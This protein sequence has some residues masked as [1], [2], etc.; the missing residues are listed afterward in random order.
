MN[1]AVGWVLYVGLVLW[2]GF[3]VVWSLDLDFGFSAAIA[4]V[5]GLVDF[6]GLVTGALVW[7]F[8]S[9]LLSCLFFGFLGPIF[10]CWFLFFCGCLC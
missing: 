4:L 7:R 10:G 3:T 5:L 1:F 8:Y 9:L 6:G 2:F